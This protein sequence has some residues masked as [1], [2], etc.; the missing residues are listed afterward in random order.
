MLG[1]ELMSSRSCGKHFTSRFPALL[2]PSSDYVFLCHTTTPDKSLTVWAGQRPVPEPWLLMWP[3]FESALLW[4]PQ[5]LFLGPGNPNSN[6]LA[7]SCLLLSV[8]LFSLA[9]IISPLN[10]YCWPWLESISPIRT[11]FKKTMISVSLW[12]P[13]NSVAHSWSSAHGSRRGEWMASGW[14]AVL[15]LLLNW[16]PQLLQ[17]QIFNRILEHISSPF[18]TG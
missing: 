13:W 10:V 9:L 17:K 1:I 6:S 2:A 16:W 8:H 12:T 15:L 7:S 11:Y 4:T 14:E 18:E 3:S 5:S